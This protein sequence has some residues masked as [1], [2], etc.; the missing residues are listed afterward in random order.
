MADDPHSNLADG[1]EA[2]ESED[3]RGYYWWN[4]NSNETTW[5]KPVAIVAKKSIAAGYLAKVQSQDGAAKRPDARQSAPKSAAAAELAALREQKRGS[6][7]GGV[8]D[9]SWRVGNMAIASGAGPAAEAAP[10]TPT[11]KPADPSVSP[12]SLRSKALSAEQ[13]RKFA[14][15]KA[16]MSGKKESMDAPPAKVDLYK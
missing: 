16:A 12:G 15:A 4:V 7:D 2:V 3:G 9:A 5:E 8:S 14:E 10:A 6:A 1:W 11:P 13:M